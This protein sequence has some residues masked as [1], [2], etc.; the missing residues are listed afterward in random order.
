MYQDSVSAEPGMESGEAVEA[1]AADASI[2]TAR[3]P[4][5]RAPRTRDDGLPVP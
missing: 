2:E 1:S 3:R 5:P 4:A